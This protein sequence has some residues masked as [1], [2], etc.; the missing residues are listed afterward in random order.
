MTVKPLIEQTSIVYEQEIKEYMHQFLKGQDEVID[1]M[2][3]V[4]HLYSV[5]L[6]ALGMGHKRDDLPKINMLITGPTGFGKTFSILKL[7]EALGLPYTRIDCS[8]V[9]AEGWKGTNLSSK[10][11][12]YCK[13]S[14]WGAGILH[15]DEFDK[16]GSSQEGADNVREH[17]LSLQQNMLDLLDGEYSFNQEDS[18]V[19]LS[20]VNNA[21]V[22]LSGSFQTTRNDNKSNRAKG[23]IGFVNKSKDD[24]VEN[25]KSWKEHL[26]ESG[27]MHEFASRIVSSVELAK[28]T[29]QQIKDIVMNGKQSAYSKFK[30][31]LG[32]SAEMTEEEINTIV[33]DVSESKNG[34][35]DLDSLFFKRYYEKKRGK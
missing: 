8:S 26:T 7:A 4:G 33:K 14:A 28:Y 35:R 11:A 20:N 13:N 18:K 2:S 31:I 16:M 25:R 3:Y 23:S 6:Y 1:L 34:M 5:K 30:N 29:P 9:S 10:V 12:E 32:L 21:L 17:K 27:F 19:P 24:D 15:L 22:I